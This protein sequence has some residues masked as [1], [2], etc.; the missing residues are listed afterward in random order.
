MSD[1]LIEQASQGVPRKRG[2]LTLIDVSGVK[3]DEYRVA[4]GQTL[5]PISTEHGGIEGGKSPF[6]TVVFRQLDADMHPVVVNK[7]FTLDRH[8]NVPQPAAE[9]CPRRASADAEYDRLQ[10][11]LQSFLRDDPASVPGPS[12]PAQPSG[13]QMQWMMQMTRENTLLKQRLEQ[14]LGARAAAPAKELQA[15]AGVTVVFLGGWGKIAFRYK[16]VIQAP[17]CII[18]VCAAGD[19]QEYEPPIDAD[20]PFDL[21]LPNRAQVLRVVNPGLSFVHAGDKLSVLVVC[22]EGAES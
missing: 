10:Q 16:D 3:S 20:R 13:D 22:Q 12:A 5:L 21:Q 7:E 4:G 2:K 6:G 9:P 17:G 18:L 15:A 14:L 8:G 19:E 1:S 11:E